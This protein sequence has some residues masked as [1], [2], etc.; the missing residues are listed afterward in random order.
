MFEINIDSSYFYVLICV[1]FGFIFTYLLYNNKAKLI[2]KNVNLFLFVIRFFYLSVIL[3]LLLNPIIK[4]N[5]NYFEDPILI[6]AKDNSTSINEDIT[7]E[8]ISLKNNLINFKSYEFS[9]SDKIYNGFIKNTGLKSNFSNLFAELNNKFEGRNV[10]G[11]ILASDGSYN[12]GLN[13]QYLSYN[14]PVY[15]IALGDTTFKKDLR[16]D[17]VETNEVTFLG[18]SFPLEVSI[19]SSIKND[20]KS[21]LVIKD[22]KIKLYDEIVTFK[23]D[24]NY[25]IFELDLVAEKVGLLNLDVK[26]IPINGEENLTNNSFT[27]YIDVIDYSSSILILKNTNTPDLA[28]FNNSISKNP[29]YNVVIKDIDEEY[30]ID[31]YQLI[32]LFGVNIIPDN[33]LNNK[34]SLIVFNSVDY[35]FENFEKNREFYNDKNKYPITISLNNRFSKFTF[36]DELNN[37]VNYAP[38]LFSSDINQKLKGNFDFILK[39][40]Q[41]ESLSKSSVMMIKYIDE[42]KIAFVTAEGFWRWKFFD[43][44]INNSNIAFDEIFL[45]LTQY[46]IIDDEKSLL[47]IKYKNDYDQDESVVINAELYNESYELVNDKE[48]KFSISDNSLNTKEYLFSKKSNTLFVDLG[49]LK[50]GRYNYVARVDGSD[51][52]KKGFFNVKKIQLEQFSDD[53]NHKTLNHISNQSGGKFFYLNSLKELESVINSS[54]LNKK[55]IHSKQNIVSFLGITNLLILLIFLILLE[56]FL[57]KYNGLV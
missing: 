45:K 13:P 47:R 6:F 57:R 10:A 48:I 55:I 24:N 11:L 17:K 56:Y 23:K 34:V 42:K 2:S 22:G 53:V 26:I 5:N 44:K 4:L 14:F 21:R 30:N 35:Y 39:N 29:R 36:S 18:N 27:K 1:S 40:K 12:T 19:A 20:V 31:K 3:L 54:A 9:F 32:V 50:P 51:E 38:P 16:I 52:N 37:L 25:K 49:I 41:E 28:A 8:L 43:Y 33:L 15:C 7:D 46:L